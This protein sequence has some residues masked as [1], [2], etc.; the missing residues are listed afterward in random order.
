M[1]RTRADKPTAALTGC[2]HLSTGHS[3]PSAWSMLTLQRDRLLD[4][5]ACQMLQIL[6]LCFIIVTRPQR[7]QALVALTQ[8]G[9]H[10]CAMAGSPIPIGAVGS[11]RPPRQLTD[12]AF[13][14]RYRSRRNLGYLSENRKILSSDHARPLRSGFL[15][16]DICT[17]SLP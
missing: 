8:A 12:H 2:S 7:E 3:G 10:T 6:N 1:G 17:L 14:R 5:G 11:R 4:L 15:R 9:F 16:F 13:M